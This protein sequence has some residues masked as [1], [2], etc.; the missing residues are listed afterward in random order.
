M[1][2]RSVDPWTGAEIRFL[3]HPSIPGVELK[4]LRSLS[5]EVVCLTDAIKLAMPAGP[6]YR[7]A[8][9]GA[10]SAVSQAGVVIG[11][12]GEVHVV[13]PAPV[14]HSDVLFID[15]RAVSSL[16]RS[17][18]GF[19]WKGFSLKEPFS[20]SRALRASF[21][22][23]AAVLAD[24]AASPL[25]AEE[26]ILALLETLEFVVSGRVRTSAESTSEREGVRRAREMIH[27]RYSESLTLQR[28]AEVSGLPKLR[29]LRTFK[30]LTG[31]PPHAYQMHLRVDHARQL[32]ASG[33]PLSD[34]AASAGFCD[35][36][37]FHRNFM[38]HHGVTPGEYTRWS[39]KGAV[40]AND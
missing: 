21:R 23:V 34:A 6:A 11:P 17:E 38:R 24:H 12:P 28:L 5:S 32:I 16:T 20:R 19:L 8:Y 29:F 4:Q 30:R 22:G 26:R 9:R 39:R 37:H 3:R 2:A 7:Y 1:G 31:L 10:T 14:I 18:G 35:Q 40:L 25:L 36:S 33:A 27:E 15:P 13:S